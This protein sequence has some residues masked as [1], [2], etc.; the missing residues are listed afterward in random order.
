MAGHFQV[1]DHTADVGLEV[2]APDLAQLFTQAALG[3]LSLGEGPLPEVALTTR[4]LELTEASA[5]LLL[6]AFLSELLFWYDVDRFYPIQVHMDTVTETALKAQ[7]AGVVAPPGVAL[8]RL[9]LKAVTYHK[10]SV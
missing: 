9:P 3:A 2:H 6:R 8:P 4:S 5:E 10:L 7:V 1:T